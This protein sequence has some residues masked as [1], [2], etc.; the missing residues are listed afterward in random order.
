ML[1]C[2]YTLCQTTEIHVY[3]QSYTLQTCRP[4]PITNVIPID[5]SRLFEQRLIL[6]FTD[7]S[8]TDTNGVIFTL[9]KHDTDCLMHNCRLSAWPVLQHFNL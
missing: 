6:Q 3:I 9:Y 1:P 8:P 4:I 5:T 7:S 2:K